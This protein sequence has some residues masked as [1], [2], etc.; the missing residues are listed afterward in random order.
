MGFFN[1]KAAHLADKRVRQALALAIDRPALA[2]IAAPAGLP[3]ARVADLV[4]T[5]PFNANTPWG[6]TEVHARL[7][8]DATEAARLLDPTTNIRTKAGVEFTFDIVYYKWRADLVAMAP[9]IRDQL[10]SLGITASIRE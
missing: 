10:I 7:P 1:T 3:A 9:Y 8:T 2:A 4:A 6:T 5:G